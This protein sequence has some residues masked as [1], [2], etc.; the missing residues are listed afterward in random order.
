MGCVRFAYLFFE[1]ILSLPS[2]SGLPLPK[3][4]SI[5]TYKLINPNKKM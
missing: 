5:S 3:C 4:K 2:V 1:E